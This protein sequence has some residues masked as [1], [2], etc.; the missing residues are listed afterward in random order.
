MLPGG[1][2]C[3]LGIARESQA[4]VKVAVRF[5]CTSLSSSQNVSKAGH[6]H[7]DARS[8]GLATKDSRAPGSSWSSS[9]SAIEKSSSK[10]CIHN[11]SVEEEAEAVG[12]DVAENIKA[13]F[14]EFDVISS[15]KSRLRVG[16]R[17]RG[18][19]RM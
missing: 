16:A 5:P 8:S 14:S 13:E 15:C 2:L 1:G 9:E 7:N 12:D 18:E 6:S 11:T 17:M 3:A 10:F 4:I 19:V